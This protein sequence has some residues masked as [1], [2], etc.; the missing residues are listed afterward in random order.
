MPDDPHH[1]SHHPNKPAAWPLISSP[2]RLRLPEPVGALVFDFD[3]VMTDNAVWVDQDG[4]EWARCDRSDGLGIG[5]VRDRGLP[6]LVLSKETNPVVTA[7]CRKLKL[8]VHQGI[9]NK[10][11]VL[12]AWLA[13]VRV[14]PQHAVYVGNDVNDLGCFGVVGCSLAPSD[15]HPAALTAATAVLHRPGGRGAVREVCDA[16]LAQL[17]RSV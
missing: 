11:P 4:R 2:E 7:R 15:A 16:V 5:L 14:T 1:S 3:G 6:M 17:A 9:D 12:L 8:P 10:V 13:E